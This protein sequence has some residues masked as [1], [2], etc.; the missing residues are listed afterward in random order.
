MIITHVSKIMWQIKPLESW[1]T[2]ERQHQ[3]AVLMTTD[4]LH[5]AVCRIPLVEGVVVCQTNNWKGVSSS[6]CFSTSLNYNKTWIVGGTWNSFL[7]LAVCIR[8]GSIDR[9]HAINLFTWGILIFPLALC[10]LSSRVSY[11]LRDAEFVYVHE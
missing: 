8:F 7:C 4:S 11:I 6:I 5:S 2:L 9:V 1:S 3:S 10:S